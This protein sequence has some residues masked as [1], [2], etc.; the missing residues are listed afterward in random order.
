MIAN[1]LR[2]Y[3]F[4]TLFTL[5]MIFIFVSLFS[6][7]ALN[8]QNGEM[9]FYMVDTED[10][11]QSFKNNINDID[12]AAPQSFIAT[13]TG[14]VYGSLDRRILEQAA[15]NDVKVMP[16][17]VNRGFDRE[18]FHNLLADE[19]A[20]NRVIHSLVELSKKYNLYGWQF[21]FEHIHIS[22]RDR[23]TDFYKKT[24]EAL[25]AEGFKLSIAVVP[26]NT[27][28]D[29]QTNYHRFLYE[30]WRAAYDLKA[31]AEI[32]DFISVMTYSQ[33]TRRTPPGP[34]AG[35]PWMKE[36]VDYMIEDLEISP[37]KIS[38]GIPFYSNWWHADYSEELGGH[39][40]GRGLPYERA[41]GMM[42]RYE[43]EVVWL[44]KQ[45][46]SYAIW[47][48]DGVFEY[49]FLEDARSIPP[50]LELMKD[51]NLLGISVWRL[52]QED[53]NVWPVIR[54]VRAGM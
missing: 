19:E 33:H 42:D 29:L 44:E 20:Q 22:D 38:L 16:L 45:Q 18:T 24:A 32:G 34:V 36:M 50:K 23:L 35:I 30:F 11:F 14:V 7:K 46:V 48:Q 1:A 4:R 53:P 8:A 31:L 13:E 17:I 25:H 52:G 12:I 6:M 9:L 51:R 28:F 21:D 54:N 43:T 3:R 37:S 26:T 49:I 10:S 2:V 15:A 5:S 41:R 40:T 47:E 27:D 39:T